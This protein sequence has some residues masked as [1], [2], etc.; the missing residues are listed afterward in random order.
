MAVTIKDIAKEAGVSYST[1][2]RVLNGVSR[3]NT[4]KARRIIQIADEMGYMPN[5]NAVNLKLAK[6]H[7]IGLYFSTISKMTS[8]FVLHDVVSAVYETIDSSYNVIV[9]GIDMHKENSLNPASYDG[10]LILSQRTEDEEFVEECIRKK[11]AV[12]VFNRIVYQEIANILTDE[13]KGVKEAMEYLLEKGHRKIAVIEGNSELDS[14]RARHRGWKQAFR[15]RGLDIEA[16]PIV[17]GNYR[18]QSGYEAA[19]QLISKSPTAI[20]CFNDEMAY[21]A[22]KAI[23][24]AGLNVPEDISLIGFDNIRTNYANIPL[25]TVERDMG[26]L[27]KHATE[28]LFEQM[29]HGNHGYQKIYL[30]TKFIERGSVFDLNEKKN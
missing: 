10:I 27:A 15:E 6:S 17:S 19:K 2:S 28:L 12:V 3:T 7:I 8:P 11:I 5:Q 13:A 25:T 14:T 21:G 23:K 20:L 16:V 30:D 1:V 24:E 4:D 18:F 26:M 9:K 29:E 22:A